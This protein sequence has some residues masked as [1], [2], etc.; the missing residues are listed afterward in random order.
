LSYLSI[1]PGSTLTT[2][3]QNIHKTRK[4]SKYYHHTTT[5]MMI[6]N[7]KITA[8]LLTTF[9][10]IAAADEGSCKTIYE[11]VCDTDGLE[12]FCGLIQST[13]IE[14]KINKENDSLTVF[15]PT[16]NAISSIS[17][18][19]MGDEDELRDILLFHIHDGALFM[20]N[21]DCDAGQNLL[22]MTSGRDSRTICDEFVPIWQKGGGNSDD[23]KPAILSKDIEACNGVVHIIDTVSSLFNNF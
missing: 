6:M 7:M 5:T 16:N 8:A 21:V 23:N 12:N 3:K 14:D 9:V 22:R 13:N 17:D 11:I 10:A 20:D 19:V 18:V 15:A 1:I 2:I 4:K